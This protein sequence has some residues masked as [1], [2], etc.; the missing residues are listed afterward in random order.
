[1]TRSLALF[2]GLCVLVNPGQGRSVVRRW[3]DDDASCAAFGDT[4]ASCVHSSIDER[5]AAVAVARCRCAAP[6]DV[7]VNS[8][9][10]TGAYLCTFGG[11]DAA[12]SPV[13]V[14]SWADACGA[15]DPS[16]ERALQTFSAAILD[17]GYL[18]ATA[19]ASRCLSGDTLEVAVRVTGVSAK[20]LAGVAEV[21][22]RAK[23]LAASVKYRLLTANLGMVQAVQVH[24][25][26]TCTLPSGALAYADD[27]GGCAAVVCDPGFEP[28]SGSCQYI[29]T[30][31]VVVGEA[32][33]E[34]EESLLDKPGV[35]ALISVGCIFC[36]VLTGAIVV[37]VVRRRQQQQ[38]AADCEP[39]G[40]VV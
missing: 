12:L 5:G 35:R 10:N 19:I 9:T 40:K 29:A 22:P 27:S 2:A 13:V 17:T 8:T 6:Y 31:T 1:M 32:A 14:T 36:L 16:Y 39:V 15:H 30:E 24:Y 25:G 18:Q 20:Y 21:L 3:C 26:A 28:K 23:T 11:V 38:A 7:V 37:A 34:D 4:A 33:Q